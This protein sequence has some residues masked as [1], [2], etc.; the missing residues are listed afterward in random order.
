M[1]SKTIGIFAAALFAS[2]SFAADL[3]RGTK[4]GSVTRPLSEVPNEGAI[5]ERIW[6]PGHDEGY[7]PQGLA[8]ADGRLVLGTYR[9]TDPKQNRGPCRVFFVIPATGAIDT[10]VDLPSGCGHAGGIAALKDGRIVVA[11]TRLLHVLKNRRVVA[12]VKLKGKLQ[13]S[14]ADSDGASLWLGAYDRDRTGQMWRMPASA[15]SRKELTER[16]AASTVTAPQRA[17]GLAVDRNGQLW[18]TVSGSRDGWLLRLDATTGD[19]QARYAMPAGIEDIA[20]DD[21]GL[22]WATSEAGSLRWSAWS[23]NFPLLFAI[24]PARL[25]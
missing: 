10:Q 15:L 25:R 21:K 7:V 3:P 13:G 16:D 23:T 2:T 1:T 8:F 20:F 19:V 11:D 14:F 22:L 5:V 24:D 17:Q 9:S 12:A 4:P 18:V 6:L